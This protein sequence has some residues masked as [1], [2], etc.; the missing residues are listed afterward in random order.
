MT[1]YPSVRTMRIV[2]RNHR[3]DNGPLVFCADAMV[4]FHILRPVGQMGDEP[5]SLTTEEIERIVNQLD[6][7]LS[8]NTEIHNS[9]AAAHRENIRRQLAVAKV[10]PSKIERL[11]DV[12]R[13]QYQRALTKPGS[14][15]GLI[16]VHS[17]VQPIYQASLNAFHAAGSLL[18]IT[19][20][21][22]LVNVIINANKTIPFA[23]STIN[24]RQLFD[25]F[26]LY[27]K[28]RQDLLEVRFKDL[29]VDTEIYN[30]DEAADIIQQ[31]V[32]YYRLVKEW[33]PEVKERV[34]LDPS[35]ALMHIKL[36][37]HL[38][39]IK[40]LTPFR[41]AKKL[42]N[43][44]SHH[45]HHVY[46]FPSPAS[47][48][49]PFID[50]I[51]PQSVNRTILN[52]IQSVASSDGGRTIG[53]QNAAVIFFNSIIGPQWD[54]MIV[55]GIPGVHEVSVQK[56]NFGNAITESVT[57]NDGRYRVK[58]RCY[59][60]NNRLVDVEELFQLYFPDARV[61]DDHAGFKTLELTADDDPRTAMSQQPY[62]YGLIKS[63]QEKSDNYTA[64]DF[65]Y[66]VDYD[67]IVAE[68]CGTTNFYYVRDRLGI[69][70]CQNNIIHSFTNIIADQSPNTYP[71][72]AVLVA[73]Y[74]CVR[75]DLVPYTFAGYSR[76]EVGPIA[77]AAFQDPFKAIWMYSLGYRQGT[78]SVDAGILAGVRPEIGT[79]YTT[80]REPLPESE[81]NFQDVVKELTGQ[82]NEPQTT[83]VTG[84]I[85]PVQTVKSPSNQ[86]LGRM[87]IRSFGPRD[88]K[89]VR[90]SPVDD[91]S[92]T[93]QST[94]TTGQPSTMLKKVSQ[95]L[96]T[97][98]T[99][100]PQ[101]IEA[102]TATVQEVRKM[103]G[104]VVYQRPPI[105]LSQLLR[106][107]S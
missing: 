55:G 29:K 35:N 7:G 50:V 32:K 81:V 19:D 57:L 64:V 89:S 84:P 48:E 103:M 1:T 41:L 91:Q 16:S 69:Q 51:V 77:S 100:V 83:T 10:R 13:T 95:A 15:R 46:V 34:L 37:R 107:F 97:E 36:D 63:Y 98:E 23:I 28:L 66:L 38:L 54:N 86:R 24:V 99:V 74:I 76:H 14:M 5:R 43:N 2:N 82:T 80:R 58:V 70:A 22:R 40:R 87:N 93:T 68:R 71:E 49:Q 27:I 33:Y 12:I 78:T 61:V 102:T 11:G 75:G 6:P 79:E 104:D 85:A 31:H 59:H 3:N 92:T 4:G 65:N 52:M 96:T 73:N 67:Y 25:D 44:R 26:N 94:T 8:F 47:I 90:F 9:V 39:Y 60:F 21:I 45:D 20:I 72:N 56:V 18:K 53:A 30:F 62:A 17:V 42:Q 106:F 88:G 105:P 101:V